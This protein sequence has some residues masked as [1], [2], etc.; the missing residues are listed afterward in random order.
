M[1]IPTTPP[2]PLQEAQ[3]PTR[4]FIPAISRF[5]LGIRSP[6]SSEVKLVGRDI[7]FEILPGGAIP[8]TRRRI[9]G[10]QTRKSPN[11]VNNTLLSKDGKPNSHRVLPSARVIERYRWIA[12]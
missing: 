10:A 9:H 11:P 12:A 4:R 8:R 1:H 6:P 2:P 3:Y 5:L 7:P